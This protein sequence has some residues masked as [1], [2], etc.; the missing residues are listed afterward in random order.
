MNN[1]NFVNLIGRLTSDVEIRTTENGRSTGTGCVAVQRNYKN[2]N[3]EYDTDFI[4]VLFSGKTADFVSKN[5]CK[6]DVISVI[7]SISTATKTTDTG[8]KRHYTNV[9]CD[10]A[11]FVPGTKKSTEKSDTMTAPV[12]AAPEATP[13]GNGTF[14]PIPADTLDDLSDDSLP[15]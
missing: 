2:A 11:G 10:S 13:T 6:G 12:S 7:G 9:V 4:Y 8:E 15:F 14:T 5:F 1:L 3:G